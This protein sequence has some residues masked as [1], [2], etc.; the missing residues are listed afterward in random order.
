MNGEW[1]SQAYG[2]EIIAKKYDLKRQE[3]DE[4]GLRS[5]KLAY[6]SREHFKK[7]IVPVS[8]ETNN[9]EGKSKVIVDFDEGVRQNTS[10]EKMQSLP[11]AFKGLELIT[12]GNSSQI[13]DGSSAVLIA[14]EVALDK[15]NLKPRAKFLSFS[16]VGVDPIT[17]LT[18]PI[19]AT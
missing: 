10:M 18:G 11:P 14:S 7:E 8:V 5:H 17:M 6:N 12:A 19:P 9:T 3:L 2:A 13:S 1:F 4:F 15:Y 16:V